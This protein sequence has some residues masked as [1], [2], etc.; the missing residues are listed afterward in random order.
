VDPASV[1]FVH[2]HAI[3]MNSILLSAYDAHCVMPASRPCS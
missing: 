2:L 3:L 1:I